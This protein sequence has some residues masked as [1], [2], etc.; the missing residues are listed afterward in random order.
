MKAGG[1]SLFMRAPR[2]MEADSYGLPLGFWRWAALTFLVLAL[3][4]AGYAVVTP[5]STGWAGLFLIAGIG[6]VAS[7]FLYLL[8]PQSR[9]VRNPVLADA[10]S[11]S[12]VAWAVTSG[13]GVVIDCNEAYRGLC[14]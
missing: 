3:A 6:I 11:N 9:S 10:A 12:S 13:D 5:P 14:G 2:P 8:W 4:A 1:D 7:L